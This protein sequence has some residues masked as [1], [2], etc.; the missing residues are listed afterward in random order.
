MKKTVTLL[1]I[2]LLSL[3]S[4]GKKSSTTESAQATEVPTLAP[5]STPTAAPTQEPSSK[6]DENVTQL[7]TTAIDAICNESND[8][9]NYTLLISGD[10]ISKED[11]NTTVQIFHNQHDEKV[12]CISWGRAS[13]IRHI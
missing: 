9:T 13:I 12:V 10:I 2:T 7:E 4:C 11:E 8:I 6:D 3:N 1:I 5:T